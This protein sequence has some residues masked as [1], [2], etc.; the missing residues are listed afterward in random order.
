MTAAGA[1]RAS[2]AA[3]AREPLA[4]LNVALGTLSI[5]VVWSAWRAARRSRA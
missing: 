4:A 1:R 5:P 2:Q 3:T